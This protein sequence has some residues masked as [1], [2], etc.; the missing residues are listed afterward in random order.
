MLMR[1]STFVKRCMLVHEV[2][3]YL[4]AWVRKKFPGHVHAKTYR[5]IDA[6][7]TL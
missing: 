6:A 4:E 2:L 5:S 7:G 3:L 1:I